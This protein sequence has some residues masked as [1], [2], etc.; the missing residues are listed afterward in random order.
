MKK[1]RNRNTRTKARVRTKRKVMKWRSKRR[2]RRSK[3]G[4]AGLV[5]GSGGEGGTVKRK[6][7]KGRW[8]EQAL[9]WMRHGGVDGEWLVRVF[10]E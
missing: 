6:V 10:V 5:S 4:G 9:Q 8:R 2:W 7:E 1:R 3:Q